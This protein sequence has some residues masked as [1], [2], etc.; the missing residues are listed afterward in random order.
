MQTAGL[1]KQEQHKILFGKVDASCE[2]VSLLKSTFSSMELSRRGD[3]PYYTG[4]IAMTWKAYAR[5]HHLKLMGYSQLCSAKLFVPLKD[6]WA[7]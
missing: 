7:Y 3:F 6:M 2:V 1:N 5:A 4:G